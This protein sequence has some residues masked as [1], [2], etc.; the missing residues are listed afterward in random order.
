MYCGYNISFFDL[1]DDLDFLHKE[2]SDNSVF[3][4]GCAKNSSVGSRL[5][6]ISSGQLSPLVGSDSL[7]TVE[8]DS[9]ARVST[10]DRL[11]A[12]IWVLHDHFAA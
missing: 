3:E 7:E 12:L 11:G 4:G 1:F 6:P 8:L 9:V 5:S 10:K 2:C